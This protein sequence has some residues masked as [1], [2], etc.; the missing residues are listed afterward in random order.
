MPVIGKCPLSQHY[1]KRELSLIS[2]RKFC[3][4]RKA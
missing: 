1:I 3:L 2:V 4:N